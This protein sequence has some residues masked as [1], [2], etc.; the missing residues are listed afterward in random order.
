MYG[1]VQSFYARERNP[2]KQSKN[3]WNERDEPSSFHDVLFP[4]V[5]G[6]RKNKNLEKSLLII[7]KKN[8]LKGVYKFY[9]VN[10]T[11]AM[12][13][14]E[15]RACFIFV[16]PHLILHCK[17]SDTMRDLNVTKPFTRD[18]R[19][20]AGMTV[21]N[22]TSVFIRHFIVLHDSCFMLLFSYFAYASASSNFTEIRRETASDPIVTP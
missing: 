19:S 4:F 3:Y 11:G 15:H 10:R 14:K 13:L 18:S 2:E 22:A 1:H 6:E 16:I 8:K 17:Q 9:S 20:E 12:F 21:G 5:F 7:S